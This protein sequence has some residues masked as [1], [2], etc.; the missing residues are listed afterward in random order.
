MQ[1]IFLLIELFLP[2][3]AQKLAGDNSAELRSRLAHSGYGL[4]VLALLILGWLLFAHLML[5]RLPLNRFNFINFPVFTVGLLAIC[6]I[7]LLM[8]SRHEQLSEKQEQSNQDALV[9]DAQSELVEADILSLDTLSRGVIKTKKIKLKDCL[10]GVV[11]EQEWE[12]AIANQY[13]KLVNNPASGSRLYVNQALIAQNST[14]MRFGRHKESSLQACIV[15]ATGRKYQV[16]I[17]FS[18]WL[19]IKVRIVVNGKYLVQSFV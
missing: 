13:C 8:L 16:A 18:A 11:P 17:F 15:D 5:Q 1:I 19:H 4:L 12:F 6:G 14:P 9:D 3:I 2:E 10:G 7:G